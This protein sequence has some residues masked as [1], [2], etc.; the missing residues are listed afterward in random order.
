MKRI[1]TDRTRDEIKTAINA[2]ID[3]RN[4]VL[5]SLNLR[6]DD[7]SKARIDSHETRIRILNRRIERLKLEWESG[8]PSA[9]Q[10][11]ALVKYAQGNG[12][13]WKSKWRRVIR[14]LK[15]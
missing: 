14:V 13:S 3:E 15:L 9:E 4:A 8:K 5:A 2:T 6:A 7:W 12:R 10:I 11:A 1:K